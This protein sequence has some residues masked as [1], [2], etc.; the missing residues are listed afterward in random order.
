MNFS[1]IKTG[2]KQ[3]M[4]IVGE[5]LTIEKIIGDFQ[6]GSKVTFDEVL[7][8]VKNDIVEMGTPTV[9]TAVEGE[10]VS[11][12]RNEKIRVV[13]YKSK[14]RY[15]KVNGHRQPHFKVKITKA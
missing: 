13:H 10:I 5:T 2:G 12:G 8:S 4:A 6:V 1:V 9:K 14:S 15:H 11:I 7:M 3:Y